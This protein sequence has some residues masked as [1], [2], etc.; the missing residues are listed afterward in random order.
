MVEAVIPPTL[1]TNVQLALFPRNDE[2]VGE[3]PRGPVMVRIRQPLETK[4]LSE[5]ESKVSWLKGPL[6]SKEL[7]DSPV[8]EVQSEMEPARTKEPRLKANPAR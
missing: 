8:L 5:A 7:P 6:A 1:L 3:L 4:S 2:M